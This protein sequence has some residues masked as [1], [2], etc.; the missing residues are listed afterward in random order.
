[1]F[2]CNRGLV[3]GRVQPPHVRKVEAVRRRDVEMETT[4]VVVGL[5]NVE[6]VSC[7][8]CPG[9]SCCGIVVNLCFCPK[10]CKGHLVEI[11]WA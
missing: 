6:T 4:V 2:R 5:A 10:R 8:Q 7:M 9:G 3:M 11:K 1:M